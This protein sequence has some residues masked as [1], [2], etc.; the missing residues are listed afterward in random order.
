MKNFPVIKFTAFFAAGIILNVYLDTAIE[1]NLVLLGSSFV[2]FSAAYA[3]EKK[4]S[5]YTFTS[6]SIFLAA[7]LLGYTS[8]NIDQEGKIFLPDSINVEKNFTAYGAIEKINLPHQNQF[9]FVLNSDSIDGAIGCYNEIRLLCIITDTKKER[10][11]G[12]LGPGNLIK[13]T[14]IYRKGREMRNPG[15]FDY[16]KYLHSKYISGTISVYNIKNVKILSANTFPVQNLIFNARKTIHGII[17]RLHT[18]E[19]SALLSGLMLADRGD[20]SFET[21]NHF[22]NAGVAH[23]LA[24]SGLHVGFITLIFYILFGRFNLFLRSILTITGVLIFMILTG[25]PPSVFRAAVMSVVI[26][27]A[28]MTNRTTN[29]YNS[30]AAA[31][32]IILTISPSELFSPGFQLS[33]SAVLSIAYFFPILRDQINKLALK[34]KFLRYLLLFTAV[35][36]SAQI[37]TLPFTLFYFSRLSLIS[38]LTNILVIPLTGIIIGTAIL[39]FVLFPVFPWVASIYASANN[40]F[41]NLLFRIVEFTGELEFSAVEFRNFSLIDAVILFIFIFAGIILSRYINSKR[42]G[43]IFVL[44]ILSNIIVYS[45]IDNAEILAKKKLNVFMI[46]VGQG[47]SFL[48]KFPDGETALIDAGNVTSFFDNGERIIIPLL[49]QLGIDIIDYGFVSHIDSDHYAG[50]VS[51]IEKGKIR[52]IFKP[53]P[54]R[55]V[56]KDILF[57]N[58]LRTHYV[59]V[60]YY[61]NRI[62]RAGNTDIFILNDNMTKSEMVSSNNQSGILKIR[63]GENSFLFTGDLEK[64]GESH[65]VELYGNF[66]DSDV[67]KIG[68]HGS[69]TSSSSAFLKE[70]SPRISLISCGIKNKYNN[71]SPEVL[72]SLTNIGSRVIRTDKEGGVLLQ[73]DGTDIRKVD[74]RKYY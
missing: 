30:L 74:W 40:F 60:E 53:Q 28:F 12:R 20:I 42:S 67:L 22:I 73:S 51:L 27:L 47:D 35:S 68:H 71:P 19:A 2:I 7:L 65:Y 4:K 3:I 15:E 49:K 66:L 32:L 16:N 39:T 57:E 56:R 21:K 13:V 10:L 58:Y 9:S 38:V 61:S 23:I 63:F 37:G 62:I 24:V 41:S 11:Y 55:N 25:V 69:K 43:L 33:F 6:I 46:D 36:V 34:N 52:K 31:A 44:L 8:E 29:I 72:G 18:N 50:F 59:D 1:L 64:K 14:G 26:L 54:E 17:T 70:V 45:A 48:I 5:S